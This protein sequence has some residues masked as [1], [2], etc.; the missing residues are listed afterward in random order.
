MTAT[1]YIA[2]KS[3]TETD[4]MLTVELYTP[5]GLAIRVI[6]WTAVRL[7]IMLAVFGWLLRS[8]LLDNPTLRIVVVVLVGL[9]A[10]YYLIPTIGILLDG[11][12]GKITITFDKRGNLMT[13]VSWRK[14]TTLP[15]TDIRAIILAS[16]RR[17]EQAERERYELFFE[18][19]D[20]AVEP[21]TRETAAPTLAEREP[22]EQLAQRI[23]HFLALE[24][25]IQYPQ[26]QGW[27]GGKIVY[28]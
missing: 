27:W 4:Q 22:Y 16:V 5:V 2:V 13:V 28:S 11:L 9:I 3:V 6:L 19:A 25:P 8:G 12:V 15:L 10:L 23:H 14:R 17:P 21:L 18:R 1:R 7:A 24:A 20:G 26:T